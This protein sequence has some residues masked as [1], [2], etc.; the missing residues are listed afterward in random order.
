MH[1]PLWCFPSRV[2]T[3]ATN[4]GGL[5]ARG[6]RWSVLRYVALGW[7]VWLRDRFG[8]YLRHLQT[9]GG[10]YNLFPSR[11]CP[12]RNVYKAG[13]TQ[14]CTHRTGCSRRH[15][16]SATRW[17]KHRSIDLSSRTAA[18]F[19]TPRSFCTTATLCGTVCFFICTPLPASFPNRLVFVWES[20]GSQHE[21]H[22]HRQ[23]RWYRR[24]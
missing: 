13:L 5:R 23:Q 9:L 3:E 10:P 14:F 24:Q 16:R 12:Y 1:E 19:V 11:S 2:R 20:S 17:R 15:C 8:Q 4:G 18:E 7:E 22:W 21:E 6:V